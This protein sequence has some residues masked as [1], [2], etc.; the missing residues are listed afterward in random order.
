MRQVYRD[1][2]IFEG[3]EFG[4]GS[5]VRVYGSVG[6]VKKVR[7]R[8]DGEWRYRVRLDGAGWQGWFPEWRL[9]G[10]PS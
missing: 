1:D 9:T 2:I 8:S 10:E 6:T 7:R 5:R 3:P 4:V